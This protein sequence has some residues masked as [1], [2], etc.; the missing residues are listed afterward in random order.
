MKPDTA[1]EP[2]KSEPVDQAFD[3]ASKTEPIDRRA[4]LLTVGK[5]AA[6]LITA[7]LPDKAKAFSF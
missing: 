4:T 5:Y 6:P 2:E 7:L 3:N 1:P